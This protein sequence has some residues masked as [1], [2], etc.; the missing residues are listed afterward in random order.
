[1]VQHRTL[2]PAKDTGVGPVH[3]LPIIQDICR[4]R[5]CR[6]PTTTLCR[7]L[8][9]WGMDPLYQASHMLPRQS[10][11]E[12]R[13]QA[14]NSKAVALQ[15][16]QHKCRWL[17]RNQVPHRQGQARIWQGKVEEHLPGSRIQVSLRVLEFPFLRGTAFHLKIHP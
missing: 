10:R 5:E 15:G 13:A 9:T 2:P 14:H 17:R 3:G 11:V 6:T 4:I 12:E 7:I 16:D 1:M 8:R